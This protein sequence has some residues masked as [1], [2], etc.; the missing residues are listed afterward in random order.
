MLIYRSP[1][2]LSFYNT[3]SRRL[4]HDLVRP[5]SK[6]SICIRYEL[7]PYTLSPPIKEF[8]YVYLLAGIHL[9]QRVFSV[10][11][12]VAYF[13]LRKYPILQMH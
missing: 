1:H 4:S 12:E 9:P 8:H 5:G 3:S 10:D 2:C 13:R 6:L 7:Y 11:F